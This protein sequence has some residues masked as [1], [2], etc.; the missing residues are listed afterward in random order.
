MFVLFAIFLLDLSGCKKEFIDLGLVLYVLFSN[1]SLSLYLSVS[2]TL[3]LSFHVVWE[4]QASKISLRKKE[5]IKY[6]KCTRVLKDKNKIVFIQKSFFQSTGCFVL[7]PMNKHLNHLGK[8]DL[9][10]W[11]SQKFSPRS[12][13][14]L[15]FPGRG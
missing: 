9:C 14:I 15:G 2:L 3:S 12:K 5:K 10:S 4:V 6:L 7:M 11:A 8:L 1:C 13:Q